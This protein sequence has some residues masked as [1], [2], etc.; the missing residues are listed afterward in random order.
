[1]T[2]PS[3]PAPPSLVDQDTAAEIS[4]ARRRMGFCWLALCAA[5]AIH[6][7]DE[8]ST[9]FLSLWNPMVKWIRDQ[10]GWIPL[11]SFDYGIWLGGLIVAIALLTGFSWFAFRGARWVRPVA[12]VLSIIMIGNALGHIAASVWLKRPA[13]G[14]AS[15]PVLLAAAACL[16]WATRRY[17][18]AEPA[19]PGP[20]QGTIHS[21]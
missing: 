3:A 5:L 12:C 14:V 18:T 19:H 1:M 7:F 10:V 16:L 21:S 6:V 4:D 9:D 20:D 15:S 11:P 8:A 2:D 17:A 13:P